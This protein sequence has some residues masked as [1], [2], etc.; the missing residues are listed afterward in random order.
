MNMPCQIWRQQIGHDDVLNW[1]CQVWNRYWLTLPI[2]SPNST[3]P[4]LGGWCINYA[5]CSDING[6]PSRHR[7]CGALLEEENFKTEIR[8]QLYELC[9]MSHKKD[10]WIIDMATSAQRQPSCAELF[11]AA[12]LFSSASLLYSSPL[13]MYKM[14]F[15]F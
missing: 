13:I 6:S 5:P 12:D 3:A 7:Y 14:Y 1:W 11:G 15:F 9:S 2:I 8:Y 10:T 4:S